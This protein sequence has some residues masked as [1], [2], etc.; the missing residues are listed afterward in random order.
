MGKS[1]QRQA[2]RQD[3]CC[4]LRNIYGTRLII[5]SIKTV[6]GL[7]YDFEKDEVKKVLNIDKDCLLALFKQQ[8]SCCG[9]IKAKNL[10]YFEEVK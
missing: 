8:A 6:S 4:S 1:V 10:L 5:P 3:M 7:A 2:T 9:G